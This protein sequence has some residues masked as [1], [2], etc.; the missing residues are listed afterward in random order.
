M[1]VQLLMMCSLN[2]MAQKGDSAANA[3]QPATPTAQVVDTTL[4]KGLESMD[5]D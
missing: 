5:E 4:V 3:P 1:M 2:A